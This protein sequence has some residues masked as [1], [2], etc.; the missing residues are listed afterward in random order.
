MRFLGAILAV[1]AALA[2]PAAAQDQ[3]RRGGTFNFAIS[4]ETPTY[5][6]A[7]TDTFAAIH[8]LAPFYSTLLK[9]DLARYPAVT[10]DLAES[11]TVSPDQLTYTF[12]LHPNVRWHD[13]TP[14]TSADI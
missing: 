2:A 5:D 12:R 3:P 10:G 14:L 11:W 8:F 4:A 7:A 13:G 9:F 6:C 1:V